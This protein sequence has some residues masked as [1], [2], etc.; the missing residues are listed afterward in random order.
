M[1]KLCFFYFDLNYFF[2]HFQ[3]KLNFI[4]FLSFLNPDKYFYIEKKMESIENNCKKNEIKGKS[5][6]N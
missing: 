2:F 5:I 1:K 6:F 3:K 4:F